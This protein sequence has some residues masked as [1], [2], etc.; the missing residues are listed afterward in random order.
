MKPRDIL[1]ALAIVALTLVGCGTKNNSFAEPDGGPDAAPVFDAAEPDPCHPDSTSYIGCDAW[2]TPVANVAWSVFDFAV[3]VANAGDK[4]ASITVDRGGA[5]VATATIAPNNLS[6]IYLPWVPELKGK[7]ADYCGSALGSLPKSVRV[8]GGAY[9]L[10]SDRPVTVYQFNALEYAP[11]GG[12]AKKDW[13]SCP[14]NQ[15]CPGVSCLSYSNDASLLFPT[16]ALTGTYRITGVASANGNSY[17]AVTATAD[18]TNVTVQLSKTAK[19]LAGGGLVDTAAGGTLTF[20]MNAG[21]VVEVSAPSGADS[22]LSGSLVKADKPVQVIAGHPCSNMPQGITACDHLEQ[23][24]LPAE[25]LGKHYFVEQPTGP[26]GAV[27]GHVVRIYGNADGT[28]LTYPQGAPAK[29]PKT[30]DAGVVVDLGVVDKDFEV[31]GD[32]AFAVV[33][34]MLGA[35]AVD[36]AGLEGD[37]SMASLVTVEQ[38]RKKYV[39]LA[40]DDYDASFV[41]AIQPMS[42]KL[43]LD[44]KEVDSAPTQIGMS[45]FGVNR[46]R[47]TDMTN[48]GAHV[49][50]STMPFGLQVLG[51]GKS[52]S[53][54]YPAGLDLNLITP[55]P[56]R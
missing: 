1:L 12:P 37:P 28:T 44:G 50:E 40:P 35:Q 27:P 14:G 31:V 52:T 53:Y 36:P 20:A 45:G 39:F 8:D 24:V 33:S 13:T 23:S 29:A 16:N 48:H 25:T 49:I 42:A 41:D 18:G 11:V 19:V 56:V 5:Q 43:V 34:L 10:K 46:I 51:Y 7:D 9:H 2:P 21:D 32:K 47:L 26:Y 15:G 6:K 55:A 17:F 38:Y 30:I 22:D 54:Q 4:P 3:V